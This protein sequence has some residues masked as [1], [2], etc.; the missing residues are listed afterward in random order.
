[1]GDY[2]AAMTDLKTAL[3]REP[4]NAEARAL[5][6]EVSAWFGDF[7]SADKEVER[8]LQAGATAER[9]RDIRYES[10]LELQRFDDLQKLLEQDTTIPP[11]RRKLYEARIALDK[12]DARAAEEH[13]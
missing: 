7:E 13:L 4:A 1:S 6:A 2:R 9:V 11:A 10:L 12:G 5:L 8:A 3:E